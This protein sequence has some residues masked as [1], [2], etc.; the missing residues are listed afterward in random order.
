MYFLFHFPIA[1]FNKQNLPYILNCTVN[2]SW[3]LTPNIN[4]GK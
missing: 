4:N 1:I 3:Y 2:Q